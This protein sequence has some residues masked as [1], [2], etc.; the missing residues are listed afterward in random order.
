M[1][2]CIFSFSFNDHAPDVILHCEAIALQGGDK[3]SPAAVHVPG[4]PRR[5]AIKRPIGNV[6]KQGTP[7]KQRQVWIHN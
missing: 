5:P 6:R 2:P 3:V 4:A 1:M 7:K